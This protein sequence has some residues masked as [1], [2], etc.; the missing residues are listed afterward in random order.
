M[1]RATAEQ[2]PD[3]IHIQA[4]L[5]STRQQ[6]FGETVGKWFCRVVESRGDMTVEMLDL[7]DWPLPVFDEPKSPASGDYAPEAEAW[8]A[9]V[10]EGDGYVIITPEYNRGY[11]AALKNAIDHVYYEWHHKPVGFLG[12]GSSAGGA[13][14]IEQLRLVVNELFMIPVRNDLNLVSARRLFDD[15]GHMKEERH[16][17]AVH[18][19]LDQIADYARALKPM[20]ERLAQKH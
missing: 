15:Q 19:M 12:Y 20:R 10:A 9:Q 6:R 7:L 1:T 16:E 13:R 2:R 17:D 14:A 4:I 3:P 8:A 11:P 18:Q 5:G